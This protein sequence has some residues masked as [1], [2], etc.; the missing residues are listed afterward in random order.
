MLLVCEVK[1]KI[2]RA[3]IYQLKDEDLIAN[4]PCVLITLSLSHDNP[5]DRFIQSDWGYTFTRV[6][7]SPTIVALVDKKKKKV[8]EI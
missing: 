4:S 5:T 7:L 1:K 2:I 8:F 3:K 6:L